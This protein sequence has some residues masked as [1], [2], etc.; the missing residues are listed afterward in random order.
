MKI[1]A[2]K[3]ITELGLKGAFYLSTIL[4]C[5]FLFLSGLFFV[6]I[7]ETKAYGE[8]SQYGIMAMYD[9]LS[10]SCKCMSGYVFGID[11]LG[12]TTCISGDSACKNDYGYGARYDSLTG[13]CKCG[14]GY[15]F[16]ND[17]FGKTKCISTTQYCNDKY[18][19]YSR[20]SSLSDNCECF[21]GFAL[22]RNSFGEIQCVS[23]DS[24]CQSMYGSNSRHNSLAD[25]CE[26]KS[27]YEMTLKSP[28]GLE[29]ISCFSKYGLHSSYDYFSKKC[30]CDSG[31]TLNNSNQCVEKQNNV[32]LT[33]KEL[34]ADERKAII[35][36]DYDYGYYLISYNSGCYSSSFK[37][38]LNQQIVVN[39]GTDFNLDTWDKIVLQD[40][41][42]TC[43][44][45]RVERAYSGTT[46]K[47]EEE[48][49]VYYPSF[50]PT[51]ISTPTPAPSPTPTPTPTPTIQQTLQPTP[52]VIAQIATQTPKPTIK[53]SPKPA[54]TSTPIPSI[55][56]PFP[57]AIPN[58][59]EVKIGQSTPTPQITDSKEKSEPVRGS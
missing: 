47:S 22:G 56:I 46:L 34:D 29:C 7:E 16:A 58:S 14:Y 42:E 38:Y 24:I 49:I 41:N 54:E 13:K 18:G 11:F 48:N 17:M 4:V 15:I 6:E 50:A 57:S 33:L 3:P 8:C 23:Q 53:P 30:E 32:Y 28:S 59:E 27:G 40:D 10:D 39:L 9:I 37:R 44:I 2:Q 12:Q 55:R 5:A 36:S 43:D 51:P 1:K 45:T 35:R 52:Q 19:V 26:C 21:S 20:Y 31:Y 25:K